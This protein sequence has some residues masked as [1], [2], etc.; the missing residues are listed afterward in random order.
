ML[1]ARRAASVTRLNFE[2]ARA[3]RSSIGGFIIVSW[4][5]AI[6]QLLASG[7]RAW[8]SG[9]RID[10]GWILPVSG[11]VGTGR[12]RPL[13]GDDRQHLVDGALQVVVHDHV[14]GLGL[15]D[16]LFELGLAEPGE[17]LVAGVAAAAQPA[18][19]LLSGGREHEDQD[20]FGVL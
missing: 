14:V 3:S 17:H 6:D 13:V 20:R 7:P 18:L 1:R 19:L 4:L 16:R 9:R 11:R 2:S 5:S 15:A 12:Q 8:G 10:S